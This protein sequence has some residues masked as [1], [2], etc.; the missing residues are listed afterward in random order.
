MRIAA[1]ILALVG[2]AASVWPLLVGLVF[3]GLACDDSCNDGAGWRNDPDA[4]QWDSFAVLGVLAFIAAGAFAVFVWRGRRWAAAL[5]LAVAAAATL[6]LFGGLVTND[7]VHHLDRRS[8]GELL[9]LTVFVFAA[10]LALILMP[11]R[12][13][14]RR[15]AQ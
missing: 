2:W 10:P 9:L 4:W 15:L 13:D 7:W 11:P 3:S 5:A 12:L 1:R 8:P 14:D 6:V